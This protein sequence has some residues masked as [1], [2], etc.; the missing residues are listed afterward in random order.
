MQR[1]Y[2]FTNVWDSI[3]DHYGAIE[4]PIHRYI[5]EKITNETETRFWN[6]LHV[7]GHQFY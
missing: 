6:K 7:K 4:T 1:L 2:F 5:S 3:Y